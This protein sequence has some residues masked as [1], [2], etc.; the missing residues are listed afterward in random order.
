MR[1]FDDSGWITSSFSGSGQQC[2]ELRRVPGGVAIRDSK[3][4]SGSV[5]LVQS[6]D[7]AAFLDEAKSGGFDLPGPVRGDAVD[8]PSAQDLDLRDVR[9]LES[10][11]R[12]GVGVAFLD[13]YVVMT[14]A[15]DAGVLV[16]D[17]GEWTAWLRGA[18]E[19]EFDDLAA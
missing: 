3:N 10:S 7:W 18:S 12:A 6:D 8:K 15:P 4:R 19:G 13:R 17:H 5:L 11:M 14:L 9:W 16:F 2:V 1:S